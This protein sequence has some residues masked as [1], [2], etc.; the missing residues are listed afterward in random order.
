MNQ[1]E[2]QKRVTDALEPLVSE[3]M[4]EVTNYDAGG[5]GSELLEL[6]SPTFLIRVLVE[7]GGS[8]P[9]LELGA[10]ARPGPRK[11]L[12]SYWASQL[13]AFLEGDLRH[14]E[15]NSFEDEAGW[16]CEERA[17]LLDEEFLNSEELR[18]WAVKASRRL[19]GQDVR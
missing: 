11:P 9:A 3:E 16:V 7:R 19:F 2:L 13:R 18:I 17:A 6:E 1:P 15:F 12:R 8:E 14:Y 5:M 4:F 10:K